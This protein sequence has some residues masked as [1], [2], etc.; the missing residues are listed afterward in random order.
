MGC[1]GCD[2]CPQDAWHLHVT[3]RPHLRWS[4]TDTAK[5]IE[6]DIIGEGIRLVHVTN[7]F[8][9]PRRNYVEMIPTQ[10]LKGAS[11]GEATFKLF[12]MARLL[13]NRGWR[14][15]R[16]KLEGGAPR[17]VRGRALY[18]EAHAKIQP[19][20]ETLAHSLRLP[21]SRTKDKMIATIRNTY[22]E[23]VDQTWNYMHYL[24]MTLG[25]PM[26]IEAAVLDTAPELD[27]E[28]INQ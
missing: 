21:L 22:P 10:H 16:L 13:S 4:L 5:A 14:I 9:E 19:E 25:Q 3:V 27:N 11:E 15:T 1:A 8:R 20:H 24:G 18:Y 28:W 6:Q 23:D 7:V 12:M 17:V 26:R 2:D